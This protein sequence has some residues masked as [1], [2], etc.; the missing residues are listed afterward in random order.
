MKINAL[1][2]GTFDP[3]TYGHIDVIKKSLKIADRLIVATTDNIN[4]DYFFSIEE[5]LNIIKKSLFNTIVTLDG[6]GQ[7]NPK[8]IT[9]LLN[10]YFSAKDIFLVGGIRKKRKAKQI[11]IL[12]MTSPI[13]RNV[14]R[15]CR[16]VYSLSNSPQV[17]Y[18]N[19]K[20]SVKKSLCSL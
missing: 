8:D 10:K 16:R 1:Y 6:D 2:P 18:H 17:P 19:T 15:A 3:I 4:K 14:R 20:K 5:R 9:L 13:P 7:N 12:R 11:Q